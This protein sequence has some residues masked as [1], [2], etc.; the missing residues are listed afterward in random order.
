MILRIGRLDGL[1][2]LMDLMVPRSILA[3]D[4][5]Q[6]LYT[7][8]FS[9]TVVTW[10]SSDSRH[11]FFISWW[12]SSSSCQWLVI[13]LLPPIDP[14]PVL[15][16]WGYSCSSCHLMVV[17]WFLSTGDLMAL[18]T[19]RSSGS[20]Y[21]MVLWLLSPDVLHQFVSP[22]GPLALVTWWSYVNYCSWFFSS[23]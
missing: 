4:G 10:W 22:S 15:I 13:W 1:E 20:C 6:D 19:W 23:S 18:V 12:F 16:S 7:W 5:S 9:T 17:L 21:L 14:P 11:L 3:P 2:N 8:S